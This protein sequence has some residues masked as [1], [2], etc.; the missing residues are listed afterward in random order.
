MTPCTRSRQSFAHEIAASREEE[1][2]SAARAAVQAERVVFAREFHDIVSH[3]VGVIAVQAGAAQVSWPHDPGTVSRAM[4]VI[5][6]TAVSA[7]SELDCLPP[8]VHPQ[9]SPEDLQGLVERIRAAG[10]VVDMT[11]AGEPTTSTADVVYRVVQESLTNVVRHAPG[12][13]VHVAICYDT[14]RTV[15]RVVDDGPGP[16]VAVAAA[17]V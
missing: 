10:T 7:L 11:M 15:V 14:G 8:K 6:A 5:E 2:R 1:L 16:T 9:R 17:T 4:A 3:A 12:A 13:A